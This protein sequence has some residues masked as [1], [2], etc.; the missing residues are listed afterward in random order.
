VLLYSVDIGVFFALKLVLCSFRSVLALFSM[1]FLHNRCLTLGSTQN[2]AQYD[3]SKLMKRKL[4]NRIERRGGSFLPIN[5]VSVSGG[6]V[7]YEIASGVQHT[8][9]VLVLFTN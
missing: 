7:G 6:R 9:N 2:S 4:A 8:L 1:E 3:D 5:S